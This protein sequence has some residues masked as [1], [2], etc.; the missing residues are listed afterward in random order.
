MKI[1]LYDFNNERVFKLICSKDDSKLLIDI[2]ESTRFRAKSLS[3]LDFS[4]ESVD[5]ELSRLQHVSATSSHPG[6]EL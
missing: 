4:M 1:E 2:P 6:S 3:I 5:S